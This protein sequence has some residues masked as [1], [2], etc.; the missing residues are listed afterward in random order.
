[1]AR[2]AK[3]EIREDVLKSYLKCYLYTVYIYIYMC[4]CVYLNIT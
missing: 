3:I 2:I 1:M 4:V